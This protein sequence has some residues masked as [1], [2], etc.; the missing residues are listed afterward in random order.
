VD[1]DHLEIP[2]RL[3]ASAANEI[4]IGAP[5]QITPTSGEQH[6][7]ETRVARLAPEA[8]PNTRTST[9]Y[10]EV[11][12]VT[13]AERSHALLPG[14]FVRA[15]VRSSEVRLASLV[16]RSAIDNDRLFVIGADNRAEPRDVGVAF[17][18]NSAHPELDPHET[19]WAA[20]VTGV[21]AGETVIT[22]NLDEIVAGTLVKPI[23]T[24]DPAGAG[25][26]G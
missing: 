14:Q 18:V 6:T 3:P 9:V 8:D 10:V 13:L 21:E 24:T 19:Q 12:Q 15:R 5:A 20:I 7:I 11:D 16:P 23:G 1:P 4:T 2:V 26:G 25:G 17:Y 22:S